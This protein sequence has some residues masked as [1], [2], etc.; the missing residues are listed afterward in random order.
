MKTLLLIVL[1]ACAVTGPSRAEDAPNAK[2]AIDVQ[3]L[4]G[5]YSFNPTCTDEMAVVNVSF[6]KAPKDIYSESGWIAEGTL[7]NSFHGTRIQFTGAWVSVD[8]DGAVT[9]GAQFFGF[10]LSGGYLEWLPNY[11]R[12][13]SKTG[14]VPEK[15]KPGFGKKRNA[16]KSRA[17]R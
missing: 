7:D 3:A 8:D 4:S 14:D 9:V 11:Q 12:G 1:A 16:G 5:R 2:K 6:R 17:R 15:P 10:T 13:L